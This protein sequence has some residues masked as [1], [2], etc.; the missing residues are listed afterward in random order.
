MSKKDIKIRTGNRHKKSNDFTK[1]T[2]SAANESKGDIRSKTNKP[3]DKQERKA[4]GTVSKK[5]KQRDS[6][7]KVSSGSAIAWREVRYGSDEKEREQEVIMPGAGHD[8]IFKASITD[9]KAN[10]NRVTR[11]VQTSTVS[12]LQL[13][14]IFDTEG[15]KR[16]TI[17]DFKASLI[18]L[19]RDVENTDT[20]GSIHS[21]DKFEDRANS[22]DKISVKNRSE[23]FVSPLTSRRASRLSS[24]TSYSSAD[25][26]YHIRYDYVGQEVGSQ[27]HGV[28]DAAADQY[29]SKIYCK[30]VD[31]IDFCESDVQR[32]HMRRTSW[33]EI[34]TCCFSKDHGL[35]PL[36]SERARALG[37][38]LHDMIYGE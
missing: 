22:D 8:F 11:G 19:T 28:M 2:S 34:P 30:I 35:K 27:E 13:T 38:E 10:F 32:P 37:L 26:G 12:Q 5:N 17:G 16:R 20:C 3:V 29:I 9:N 25:Y 31:L 24:F 23:S 1:K 18:P 4:A 21:D 6:E 14:Q 36:H 33:L 7:T 15:C